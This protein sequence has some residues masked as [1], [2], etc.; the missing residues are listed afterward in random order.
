MRLDSDGMTIAD[1]IMNTA[2]NTASEGPDTCT[3]GGWKME[4]LETDVVILG[5]GGA[6]MAAAITAAEGG[7]RVVVLEKRPFPGGA[8]NT[9]V[10]LGTVAKDAAYRDKAFKV[11][12]E[13]THW[14][15]NAD[16][17]RSYVDM[18]GQLLSGSVAWGFRPIPPY[19]CLWRRSVNRGAGSAVCP[20]D[21]D[22]ATC[23][24]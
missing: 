4:H 23:V 15:G 9:P 3:I 11:F 19:G 5:T 17:V 22:W 2:K 10:V 20:A 6:G 8:S 12:M 21:T 16:L 7:A 13:M 24:S 14:T 1:K 18:S